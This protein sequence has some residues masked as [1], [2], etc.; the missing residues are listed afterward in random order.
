MRLAALHNVNRSMARSIMSDVGTVLMEERQRLISR[1]CL[2]AFCVVEMQHP[3]AMKLCHC[4][5]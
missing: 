1:S 4:G 3:Y 5:M 2:I